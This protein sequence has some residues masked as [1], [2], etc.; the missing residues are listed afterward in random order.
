MLKLLFPTLILSIMFV[1]ATRTWPTSPLNFS[2]SEA[3]AN[4]LIKEKPE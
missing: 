3:T 1:L 2:Q 4:N